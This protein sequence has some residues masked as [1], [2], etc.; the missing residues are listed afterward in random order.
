MDNSKA[1]SPGEDIRDY[2]TATARDE[3][4]DRHIRFRHRV[5]LASWSSE[6]AMWTV[7]AVRQAPDGREE[8]VT[9]TCNF[10]FSCA[11]YYRYD[12]GY[13]PNSRRFAALRVESFIRNHGPRIWITRASA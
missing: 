8:A 11:G 7:E 6:E 12:A 5:Q 3:G 13:M 4:I 10:L 2:I 1:I 9:L